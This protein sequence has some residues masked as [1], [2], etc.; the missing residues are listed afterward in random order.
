[1]YRNERSK[2]KIED[3]TKIT[4]LKAPTRVKPE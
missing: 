1:M 2:F 3:I 4:I